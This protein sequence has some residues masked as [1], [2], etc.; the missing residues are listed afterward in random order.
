MTNAVADKPQKT[1]PALEAR[2]AELAAKREAA[3]AR[4][5]SLSAQAKPTPTTAKVADALGVLSRKAQ[6]A[7]GRYG[8]HAATPGQ[9]P[10]TVNTGK[11]WVNSI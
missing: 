10:A 1:N 2:R 8:T 11:N 3:T 6:L 5:A 9:T 4:G 7:A